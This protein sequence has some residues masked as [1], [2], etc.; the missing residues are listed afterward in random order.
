MAAGTAQ[1][2]LWRI[3]KLGLYQ[4]LEPFL[5]DL[6]VYGDVGSAV[7]GPIRLVLFVA[8]TGGLAAGTVF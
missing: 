5:G 2:G 6:A 4:R 3:V 7:G 8:G 1:R